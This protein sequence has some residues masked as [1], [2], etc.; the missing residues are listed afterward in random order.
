MDAVLSAAVVQLVV[1]TLL[2]L[3]RLDALPPPVL[4]TGR[5]SWLPGRLT[6]ST[7]A[8][9]AHAVPP[10]PLSPLAQQA[11]L[12]RTPACDVRAARML[13]VQ[14]PLAAVALV[15]RLVAVTLPAVRRVT[16]PQPPARSWLPSCRRALL[17][18]FLLLLQLAPLATVSHLA[19]L[20][21]PAVASQE[22]PARSIGRASADGR[23]T[24]AG[25]AKLGA[26]TPRDASPAP[27]R[28]TAGRSLLQSQ[29]VC[30]RLRGEGGGSSVGATAC[31]EG[32]PCCLSPPRAPM[33]SALA[34][35]SG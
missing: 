30:M 24:G 20:C 34:D 19:A 31:M 17:P 8:Q 1:L 4:E 18:A 5:R 10:H 9:A 3:V 22:W 32:G 21:W 14:I 11:P 6:C 7:L 35:G 2:L 28:R 29:P 27:P 13:H 16:A 26:H 23:A 25:A 15:L 33:A 12:S